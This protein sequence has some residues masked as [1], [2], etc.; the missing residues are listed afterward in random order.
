MINLV[1][2]EG[3]ATN[4]TGV[5]MLDD[6]FYTPVASPFTEENQHNCNIGLLVRQLRSKILDLDCG[7][8]ALLDNLA[9]TNSRAL[10]HLGQAMVKLDR[11]RE[12]RMLRD[13]ALH[14]N[15][16]ITQTE[17]VHVQ[18][19]DSCSA[20]QNILR[21]VG[22]TLEHC[23]KAFTNEESM[24]TKTKCD[25]R[26]QI[27]W[28]SQWTSVS[29][30]C[31]ALRHDC[32]SIVAKAAATIKTTVEL[33][34][35]L[36]NS[37][38]TLNTQA[39]DHKLVVEHMEKKCSDLEREIL[40][41]RTTKSEMKRKKEY[42]ESKCQELEEKLQAHNE[43]CRQEAKERMRL[44]TALSSLEK[45]HY[46]LKMSQSE[47]HD[48]MNIIKAHLDNERKEKAHLMSAVEKL[49]EEMKFKDEQINQLYSA[50]TVVDILK[51]ENTV[52]RNN[53]LAL[54][55]KN[56]TLNL[57]LK[58]E[59]RQ[60]KKQ[61]SEMSRLERSLEKRQSDLELLS[62]YPDLNGP[63]SVPELNPA[64]ILGSM[65]KQYEA[66]NVRVEL[67]TDQNKRLQTTIEKLDAHLRHQ[68]LEGTKG[69][70]NG[71]SSSNSSF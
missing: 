33:E 1:H 64:D 54:K 68:A 41:E 62:S 25:L 6:P 70:K 31:D 30:W 17:T 34:Q 8:R 60:I 24:L 29:R 49:R 47:T 52:L 37:Q 35:K 14:S 23:L 42:I 51:K 71:E 3:T 50:N 65:R 40:A 27:F 11:T 21:T 28:V 63:I 59:K 67:L 10:L 46:E 69:K 16:A 61:K 9:T 15:D 43:V 58:D 20:S 45:I 26:D 5:P 55:K 2:P 32:N 53:N 57:S 13:K 56:E 4:K 36:K 19:C 22:E 7:V 39:R 12:T 66:N 48:N 44:E 18:C 38:Q